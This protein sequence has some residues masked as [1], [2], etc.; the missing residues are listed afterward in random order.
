MLGNRCSLSGVRQVVSADAG[1]I[2]IY[3]HIYIYMC[4]AQWPDS[5][6]LEKESLGNKCLL[7]CESCVLGWQRPCAGP[8]CVDDS[9]A[10][11][12]ARSAEYAC[13]LACGKVTLP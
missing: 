9:Y 10:A 3:I 12:V 11:G 4:T 13:I 2:Y 8:A 6:V 5:D 7:A 1:D